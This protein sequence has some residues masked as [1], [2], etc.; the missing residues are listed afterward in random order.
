[1]SVRLF[2]IFP[3]AL[4]VCLFFL[5]QNITSRVINSPSYHLKKP[6]GYHLDILA[7]SLCTFLSS[8]TGLPWLVAAT[9]QSLNHMSAL[10]YTE[11]PEPG[12]AE[13][14]T[15]VLENR[16][17]NIGVNLMIGASL[18]FLPLLS[19][20]PMGVIYGLFL[21]LGVN[22]IAGNHF[23]RRVG[24]LIVDRTLMDKADP[25][26]RVSPRDANIFTAVQ[27]LCLALMWAIKL[28]KR[29]SLYFPLVIASLM[30]VRQYVMPKLV[31]ATALDVL[32]EE[33]G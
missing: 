3:A 1:M 30:L 11:P 2:A 23:L 7:L 19:L 32:D 12:H 21:F 25:L 17:T 26:L 22:M 5:D 27:A 24:S 28:D 33:V 14:T 13:R 9:V 20:V 6:P 15:G 18:L 8:I 4:L 10:S 16:V 29:T 31:S